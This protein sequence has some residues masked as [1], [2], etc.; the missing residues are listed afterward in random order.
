MVVVAAVVAASL[1]WILHLVF[2]GVPRSLDHLLRAQSFL[3]QLAVPMLRTLVMLL[4]LKLHVHLVGA[5]VDYIHF[6][7]LVGVLLYHP[8]QVGRNVE[9]VGIVGRA[10]N[11]HLLLC[12]L[13]VS[14]LNLIGGEVKFAA[15]S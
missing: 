6:V 13:L 10:W 5:E 4:L 8:L 14:F 3:L 15:A 7:V 11:L 12:I 2:H 9:L 1:L